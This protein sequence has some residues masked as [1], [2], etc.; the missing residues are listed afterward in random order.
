[1]WLSTVLVIKLGEFCNDVGSLC[2]H[3]LL[4][5]CGRCVKVVEQSVG[6]LYHLS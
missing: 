2:G 5:V 1:V 4:A 6:N 3:V